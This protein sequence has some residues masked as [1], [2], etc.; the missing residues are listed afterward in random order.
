[1][2]AG[3]ASSYPGR[4]ARYGRCRLSPISPPV[5]NSASPLAGQTATVLANLGIERAGVVAV[6]DG[7]KGSVAPPCKV[8][9]SDSLLVPV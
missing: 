8:H 2:Q 3:A 5:L 6:R 1:M 9:V 4:Q 7:L